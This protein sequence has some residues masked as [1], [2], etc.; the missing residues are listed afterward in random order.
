MQSKS[1]MLLTTQCNDLF[2]EIRSNY[3]LKYDTSNCNHAYGHYN[4][5]NQTTN[6]YEYV[7]QLIQEI[8]CC[9][10][11]NGYSD[12]KYTSNDV[13]RCK[14]IIQQYKSSGS[15]LKCAILLGCKIGC[16]IAKNKSFA[17]SLTVKLDVN[18]YSNNILA[19]TGIIHSHCLSYPSI[20]DYFMCKTQIYREIVSFFTSTFKSTPC[21][22]FNEDWNPGL[23]IKL[24]VAQQLIATNIKDEQWKLLIFRQKILLELFKIIVGELNK[25]FLSQKMGIKVTETAFTLT[26][27]SWKYLFILVT[28][29]IY[30]THKYMSDSQ[31]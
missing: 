28:L 7:G 5:S 26:F 8:D 31:K 6:E 14:T 4:T 15:C 30:R 17:N 12:N 19:L 21:I 20:S 10:L 27:K 24:S 13:L 23:Y 18:D 25:Y 29:I 16:C 3:L 2:G 1:L 11:N 22:C 9:F